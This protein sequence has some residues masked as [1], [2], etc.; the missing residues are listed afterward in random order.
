MVLKRIVKISVERNKSF[1]SLWVIGIIINVM[2]PTQAVVS[3]HIIRHLLSVSYWRDRLQ[4]LFWTFSHIKQNQQNCL[5]S[6]LEEAL[7]LGFSCPFH[8]SVKL[9]IWWHLLNVLEDDPVTSAFFPSWCLSLPHGRDQTS[10]VGARLSLAVSM[11][12]PPAE[13][14]MWGQTPGFKEINM[15]PPSF[16]LCWSVAAWR[17]GH[18]Q[19]HREKT[20]TRYAPSLF[21]IHQLHWDLY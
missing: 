7:N 21:P 17:Q 18:P 15:L 2:V 10:A 20:A 11:T 16:T 1:H 14:R 5:R 13:G 6:P 12:T 19:A 4:Q 8:F 9:K 3:V